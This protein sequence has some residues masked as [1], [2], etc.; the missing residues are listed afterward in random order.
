MMRRPPKS[1]TY[2]PAVSAWFGWLSCPGLRRVGAAPA[3]IRTSFRPVSATL[4]TFTAIALAIVGPAP[5]VAQTPPPEE[6]EIIG[7]GA[8]AIAKDLGAV[9]EE[10][11]WDAKRNAV[12]QA[13]GIFLR[14]RAIGRDFELQSDEIEGRTGG[15]IRKWAVLPGSRKIEALGG[16]RVLRLQVK[17]TV[18]LLPVIRKLTDIK[19]VYEDLERPRI[20]VEITNDSARRVKD[21]IAASLKAQGFELSRD[22]KAEILISGIVEYTPTLRLGDRETP[23][24][25]GER[26]A[27]CR[28]RLSLEVISTASEAVL[29]TLSGQGSG[30]SFTSDTEARSDSAEAAAD[31]LIVEGRDQFRENLLVRWA[32]ERQEGHII[33][34]KSTGV[35]SGA[36]AA[37][38]QQIAAM[39]GFRKFISESTKAGVYTLRLLTRLDTRAV[40]RRLAALTL[41]H[42]EIAVLDNRGPLITCSVRPA[43]RVS[44]R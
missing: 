7:S 17:A 3:R 11:I 22:E 28:A 1:P 16:G 14:A 20:R 32:R 18:A 37:I 40:R 25:I 34:L 33:A 19:D 30:R 29:I 10:A 31:S 26:M 36:R 9:E 44:N 23:Y 4:F 6:I 38:R 13:A 8:A 27:A 2:W 24:G 12:E 42:K 39:R 21:A 5:T 35:D 43:Q 41:A 15:F